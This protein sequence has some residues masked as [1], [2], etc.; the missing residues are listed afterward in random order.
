MRTGM[1]MPSEAV[2]NTVTDPPSF[3]SH[4]GMARIYRYPSTYLRFPD[5]R[6]GSALVPVLTMTLPMGAQRDTGLH[7]Q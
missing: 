3:L 2:Y 4:H 5:T 6:F 1:H 7:R